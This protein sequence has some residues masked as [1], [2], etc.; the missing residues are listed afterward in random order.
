MNQKLTDK[1]N[2]GIT[3]GRV[4]YYTQ[5][6][7]DAAKTSSYNSGV[8]AGSLNKKTIISLG[9]ATSFNLTG[10][11]NY[12]QFTN[13]NFIVEITGGGA[14]RASDDWNN[15]NSIHVWGSTSNASIS[16][17]YNA[18]TGILTIDAS[19]SVFTNNTNKS[20]LYKSTGNFSHN[21][22]LIY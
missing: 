21:T 1:Y 22:Y 14:A 3:D 2:A 18:N 19:I 16:K 15:T 9:T 17:L 10:Y 4:G 5:A 11:P 12:N 20:Q 7:L 6:Q 13:D 8:A